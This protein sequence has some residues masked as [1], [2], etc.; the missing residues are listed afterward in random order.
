MDF[1]WCSDNS[2]DNLLSLPN[3][4]SNDS[5]DDSDDD[6]ASKS[7]LSNQ[8]HAYDQVSD[9][10][11]GDIE[12]TSAHNDNADSSSDSYIAYNPGGVSNDSTLNNAKQDSTDNTTVKPVLTHTSQW[13]PQAMG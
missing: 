9:T 5:N 12:D 6:L 8:N 10:F 4:D 11:K 13:M 1:F 3:S 7:N 2:N